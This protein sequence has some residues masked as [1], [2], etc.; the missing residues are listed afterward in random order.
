ME[1]MLKKINIKGRAYPSVESSLED[2]DVKDIN[3]NVYLERGKYTGNIKI[4]GKSYFAIGNEIDEKRLKF[5]IFDYKDNDCSLLADF[6]KENLNFALT[7]FRYSK[8]AEEKYDNYEHLLYVGKCEKEISEV[9][10]SEQ[11]NQ[12]ES[13][14]IMLDE[15][16][17]AKFCNRFKINLL[18]KVCLNK[19]YLSKIHNKV[20]EQIIDFENFE[21]IENEHPIEIVPLLK[22]CNDKFIN[23]M[24]DYSD[25]G[26][27][28]RKV[29]WSE[30]IAQSI[31][32][33]IE[34]KVQDYIFNNDLQFSNVYIKNMIDTIYDVI[35]K[36]IETGK[37]CRLNLVELIDEYPILNLLVKESK[38][39]I[40][41]SMIVDYGREKYKNILNIFE[42]YI[43]K[44]LNLIANEIIIGMLEILGEDESE[45]M[46][47]VLETIKILKNGENVEDILLK[48]EASCSKYL[49]DNVLEE[50]NFSQS[51]FVS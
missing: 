10:V 25:N 3:L 48:I 4:D 23:M 41:A 20:E 27:Y 49:D 51:A 2:C 22:E 1:E 6:S 8:N 44:D 7:N 18:E 33:M 5:Y 14:S 38:E 43:N 21:N 45:R 29:V 35:E 39:E 12:D 36:T 15:D 11:M 17:Y 34:N 47:T 40:I 30:E 16:R 26:E 19:D 50:D 31:Y 24:Y 28:M 42:K 13:F 9:P 32:T 37:E 46:L